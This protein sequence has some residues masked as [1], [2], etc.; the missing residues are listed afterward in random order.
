MGSVT[1]SNSNRLRELVEQLG[2]QSYLLDSI[3][4]IKWEWFENIETIGVT[5]GAS[6]PD[7]LV[8]QIIRVLKEI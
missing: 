6:A 7:V 8:K 5:A 1:S 4:Q 2:K 3:E